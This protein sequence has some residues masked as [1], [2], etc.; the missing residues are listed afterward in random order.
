MRGGTPGESCLLCSRSPWGVGG[1]RVTETSPLTERGTSFPLSGLEGG[2]DLMWLQVCKV[3]V[4]HAASFFPCTHTCCPQMACTV[5][6]YGKP[7]EPLVLIALIMTPFFS[8]VNHWLVLRS[9]QLQAG[10][11]LSW[12][13]IS[14]GETSPE[15]QFPWAHPPGTPLLAIR[16]YTRAKA[17]SGPWI[18]LPPRRGPRRYPSSCLSS[19]ASFWVTSSSR[20]LRVLREVLSPLLHSPAGEC[21]TI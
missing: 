21:I 7:F 3:P 15:L 17:Y 13:D 20:S 2:A 4:T 16:S 6:S 5:P 1:S 9:L 11:G 18:P 14:S 10:R 12:K 19:R 8:P